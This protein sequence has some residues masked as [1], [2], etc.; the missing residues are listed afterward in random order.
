MSDSLNNET[1]CAFHYTQ[2]STGTCAQCK[3]P[4]CD[5][6]QYYN[7]AQERV[8]PI[9]HNVEKAKPVLRN[10]QYISM[11]IIGIGVI[12][13]IRFLGWTY[14]FL[15]LLLVFALPYFL[16]PIAYRL[17]F[18]NLESIEVI[19]PLLRYFE[20]LGNIQQYN[21]ALK[22]IK[23]LSPEE[24]TNF[25]EAIL[26]FLVPAIMFNYARLP[27]EWEEDLV[28]HLNMSIEEFEELLITKYRKTIINIAVK[29]AQAEVSQFI[30]KLGERDESGEFVKEYISAI[31]SVAS[32]EVND[33]EL[34]TIYKGLL[35]ELY[36]YEE[37]FYSKCDE[38]GLSKEKEAIEQLVKRFVPPP[39]PKTKLEALM[40]SLQQNNYAQAKVGNKEVET[41][42]EITFEQQD[43]KE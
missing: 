2:K 23:K 27:K 19:L 30:F 5:L 34:N 32:Q 33:E 36:I 12:L 9:C 8:C 29:N 10:I 41:E 3:L 39:V 17:Y 35:E 20:A 24:L 37:Q 16:Q 28:K 25:K 14:A 40:P 1:I 42:E 31:A 22:Y 7:Q 4:I 11:A 18:K 6:D 21:I 13:T 38:L 26:Q 15:L 43:E